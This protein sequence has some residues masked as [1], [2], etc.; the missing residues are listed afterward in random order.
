MQLHLQQLFMW[1]EW[2]CVT[3]KFMFTPLGLYVKSLFFFF[4]KKGNRKTD[5]ATEYYFATCTGTNEPKLQVWSIKPISMLEHTVWESKGSHSLICI[6]CFTASFIVWSSIIAKSICFISLMTLHTSTII[7][8]KWEMMHI[9]LWL[10]ITH[11]C[12]L[13]WCLWEK[14]PRIR[15]K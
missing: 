14:F 1:M 11:P 10:V 3:D 13:W 8:I 2:V 9:G 4:F 15:T 5:K 6:Y 7:P 12:C